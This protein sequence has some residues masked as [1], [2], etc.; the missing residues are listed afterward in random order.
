MKKTHV[1]LNPDE[2]VLNQAPEQAKASGLLSIDFLSPEMERLKVLARSILKREI[3]TLQVIPPVAVKLLK[4]TNDE[5]SS[6]SD[7]SIIIETEPSLSIEVLR[8]V[9]SA[10]YNYPHK[11]VSIKRAVTLLG[12]SAIRQIA[13][14]LLFFKKMIKMHAKHAFDQIFFWQHCLF[15]ATLSKIIARE[16]NHSDPDMVYAA[17]LLHDIGKIVLESHGQLTYSDYMISFEK[18]GSSS[19][20]NEQSFFGISHDEMG[21]VFCQTCDLPES[22]I[23]VVLNH[24]RSFSSLPF[25]EQTR[26]NISIV[27]Y[28]NFIA[29]LQGIGSVARNDYPTLQPEVFETINACN[30][31][32][33]SILETVDEELR[34]ISRFYN[35]KFPSLNR[36]RA[37]LI[38][39]IF[40]LDARHHHTDTKEMND[41]LPAT[42]FNS[43]TV[44]H[45]SLNP[46]EFIPW[47]LEA[48]QKEFAFERLILL[49]ID[50]IRRSLVTKYAWP[51]TILKN[52]N[53]SFEIKISSL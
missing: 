39:T 49:D 17:G 6:F 18:T 14:N 31:D 51:E 48:L 41:N 45:H 47:T 33:E 44:P 34:N 10:F 43:L 19:I 4:L 50:P 1:V 25:D 27:A 7:L 30:L 2:N 46:D 8:L 28:A 37:N 26:L 29:W 24:H 3:S 40:N 52:N 13:L 32:I 11:I 38:G 9:N 5:A 12:F 35:F 23:H 36:L 20:V 42:H 15:V 21:A 53:E 16:V 22:I